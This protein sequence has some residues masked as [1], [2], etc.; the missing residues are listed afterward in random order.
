[1]SYDFKKSD[2]TLKMQLI[3]MQLETIAYTRIKRNL[4]DASIIDTYSTF[5][6]RICQDYNIVPE[7]DFR[8]EFITFEKESL[9]KF[10]PAT[11]FINMEQKAKI[12]LQKMNIDLSEL[13]L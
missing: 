12:T 8:E 10:A 13:N 7:N 3:R 2:D 6:L 11:T 5:W 1:M 4:S 9:L